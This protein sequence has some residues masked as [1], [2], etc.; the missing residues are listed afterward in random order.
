M[1]VQE[2]ITPTKQEQD[3]IQKELHNYRESSWGVKIWSLKLIFPI[4]RQGYIQ[5]YREK[6]R[7]TK[8]ERKNTKYEGQFR[9]S[10][11][12]LLE[13]EKA[14]NSQRKYRHVKTLGF[15]SN[16]DIINDLHSIGYF[17]H[18]QQIDYRDMKV[19]TRNS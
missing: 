3:A 16:G 8:Y 17:Q 10:S 1:E 19:E 5:D 2:N 4:K 7:D 13:T 12:I 6:H 15:L 14:G 9:I 11:T 18:Q